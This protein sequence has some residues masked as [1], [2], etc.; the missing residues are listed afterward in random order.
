MW[1][2]HSAL[3]CTCFGLAALPSGILQAYSAAVS[4]AASGPAGRQAPIDPALVAVTKAAR[5]LASVLP[6]LGLLPALLTE[7]GVRAGGSGL[8]AGLVRLQANPCC[9]VSHNGVA[10]GTQ[11]AMPPML[12]SCHTGSFNTW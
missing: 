6:A 2:S 8:S 5:D 7:V 3:T 11:L 4:A 10:V 9:P 12:L 1:A